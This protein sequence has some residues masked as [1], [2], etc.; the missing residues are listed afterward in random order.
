MSKH[1][2]ELD[3]QVARKVFGRTTVY[4]GWM[5]GRLSVGTPLPCYS[6]AIVAAWQVVEKMLSSPQR[7]RDYVNL[8]F[9]HHGDYWTCEVGTVGFGTGETAPLAICRA[10]LDAAQKDA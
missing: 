9:D 6:S 7:D 8:W 3:E 5:K 1:D 2:R 10:A 4:D